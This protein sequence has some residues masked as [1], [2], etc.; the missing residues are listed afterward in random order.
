VEAAASETMMQPNGDDVWGTL[1]QRLIQNSGPED[2]S[3][4]KVEADFAL[5]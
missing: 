2:V 3:R 5:N 4:Q 1:R